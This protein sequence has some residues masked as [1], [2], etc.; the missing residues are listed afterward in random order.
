MNHRT[1]SAKR[2]SYRYRCDRC[3]SAA[4]YIT[5]TPWVAM[6]WEMRAHVTCGRH[7]PNGYDF[8]LADW[9]TGEPDW[10]RPG[11]LYTMREHVGHKIDGERAVDLVEAALVRASR[12][13][14]R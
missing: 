2:A 7:L 9:F 6:G 14:T 10:F 4:R 8:E 11:A 13:A 5:I 12:E 1:P 3:G